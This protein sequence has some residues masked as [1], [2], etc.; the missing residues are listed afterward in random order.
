MIICEPEPEVEPRFVLYSH[1]PRTHWQTFVLTTLGDCTLTLSLNDES[2]RWKPDV[3]TCAVLNVK[4]SSKRTNMTG[5]T[6]RLRFAA[7]L[8]IILP[9]PAPHEVVLKA[10]ILLPYLDIFDSDSYPTWRQRV[11]IVIQKLSAH[12]SPEFYTDQYRRFRIK[13]R[14][15]IHPIRDTSRTVLECQKPMP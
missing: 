6:R 14:S 2:C 11:L 1:I 13:Y 9:P 7:L 4:A 12:W 8:G 10:G 15:L 5:P 3:S